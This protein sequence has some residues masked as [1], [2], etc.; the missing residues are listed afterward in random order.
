MKLLLDELAKAR[1][2]YDD[3]EKTLYGEGAEAHRAGA[4][5][6]VNALVMFLR[7]S[8]VPAGDLQPLIDISAALLVLYDRTPGQ[9]G[10]GR[11]ARGGPT[12]S[13]KEE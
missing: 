7:D 6:A 5:L 3:R 11:L 12:R 8:R 2:I 9:S 4:V 13:T 1:A 10:G